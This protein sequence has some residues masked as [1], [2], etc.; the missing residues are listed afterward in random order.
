M[1]AITVKDLSEAELRALRIAL[2]RLAEAAE[3]DL[4]ELALELQEI[5]ELDIDFDVEVAGF[6]TA[7]IDMLIEGLD[8]ACGDDEADTI[9]EFDE[10]GSAVTQ[11]GD[12]WQLG[13]HRLLCGDATKAE[14]FQ[15]LLGDDLAQMIFSDPP[16][17]VSID[18]HVC[19]LGA[20][21]HREFAM[22][23]GEMSEAQ[24][25]EFLGTV[26]RHLVAHSVEGSLHFVCMD[27]RH[28]FE[29]LSAAR[30]VYSELKNLCIWNKTNGGMG[31]LYRSK[32]ELVFVLK[33]G[34]AAH[35]NNI[36]LGKYGRYRSNVWDYAGVNSLKAGRQDELAMHPTTKPVALVADAIKD[37]SRRGQIVLDAFSGSG[38]T[39]IAAEKTARRGYALELDPKYV[40][41]A[42]E[43]WQRL[44]GEDAVH[45]KS[46]L[47]FN[48]L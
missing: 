28:Q 16:Y 30:G 32:H 10:G 15:H 8:G 13:S 18:G 20:V 41:V 19:G 48:E 17:N 37:C 9:P 44:T 25:T 46:G 26:F 22:A 12:L 29:L 35:I 34:T 43:R 47:S 42:I 36:E 14:V 40:D 45:V 11:P 33:N 21:K 7:E 1:P 24:F 27:W 31:S 3:W 4:P 38:T 23:S 6:Q 5:V 39:I 2:N